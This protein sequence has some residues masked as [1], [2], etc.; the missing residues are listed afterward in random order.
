M[1]YE[2]GFGVGTIENLSSLFLIKCFHL[3]IA[4]YYANNSAMSFSR[5][6]W[7]FSLKEECHAGLSDSSELAWC[8]GQEGCLLLPLFI[9]FRIELLESRSS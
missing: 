5:L 3:E 8:G 2:S 6:R 4:N 1:D 9:Q 7:P